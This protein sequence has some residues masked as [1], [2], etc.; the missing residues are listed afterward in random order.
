MRMCI[1]FFRVRV[2]FS[3]SICKH[4]NEPLAYMEGRE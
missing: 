1:I 2:E 3:Y 4:G